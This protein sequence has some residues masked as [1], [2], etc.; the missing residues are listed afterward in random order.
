M[1]YHAFATEYM[2]LMSGRKN[3][4]N[5][6]ACIHNT[7]LL[8]QERLCRFDPVLSAAGSEHSDWMHMNNSCEYVS[9][10][11]ALHIVWRYGQ[12]WHV[13]RVSAVF[14]PW[15]AGPLWPVCNQ[16]AQEGTLVVFDKQIL[17]PA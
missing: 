14:T 4:D 11:V 8:D 17:Q 2:H 12:T 13:T 5:V 10:P 16:R 1:Q 3:A 15:P 6:I 7:W 9:V